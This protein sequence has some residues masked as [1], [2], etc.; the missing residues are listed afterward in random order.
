MHAFWRCQ[1]VL[2]DVLALPEELAVADAEFL[3]TLAAADQLS[4]ENFRTRL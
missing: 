4:F 2:N 1:S 3:A